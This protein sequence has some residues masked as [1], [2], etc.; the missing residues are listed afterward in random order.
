MP[1]MMQNMV[2]LSSFS[3]FSIMNVVELLNNQ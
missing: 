3:L 2:V 1:L